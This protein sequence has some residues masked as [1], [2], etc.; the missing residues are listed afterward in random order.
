MSGKYAITLWIGENEF[1]DHLQIKD[2]L[3]FEVI[4]N[5]CWGRGWLPTRKLSNLWWP[6]RFEFVTN[7]DGNLNFQIDNN[8]TK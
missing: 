8:E 5:D 1:S 3:N 7:E 6:T 2:A 4:E